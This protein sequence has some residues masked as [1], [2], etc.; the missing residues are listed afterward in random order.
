MYKKIL[1]IGAESVSR[2]LDMTDRN[3][4]ILFGD[5]ACAAVMGEVE[6][7]YGIIS[8]YMGTEGVDDGT[9]RIKA[10]GTMILPLLKEY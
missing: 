1:V 3:T 4:A 7:G 9:L 10:G 2:L 8:S 6:E 5:G